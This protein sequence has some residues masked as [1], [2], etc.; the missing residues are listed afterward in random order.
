MADQ[1]ERMTAAPALIKVGGKDYF[2]SP[3]TLADFATLEK[4]ARRVP[5]EQLKD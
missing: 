2:L 1:L 3:I 5:F 4:W